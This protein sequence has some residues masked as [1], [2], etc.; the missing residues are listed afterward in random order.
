MSRRCVDELRWMRAPCIERRCETLLVDAD[1]DNLQI[2]GLKRRLRAPISRVLD[3]S[4]IASIR[5]QSDA[6]IE[7]LPGTFG[8]YDLRAVTV[9]A[10]RELQMRGDCIAQCRLANRYAVIERIG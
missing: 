4:D 9:N 7:R 5:Q 10:A 6:E 3:P 8:D 1:R 2:A